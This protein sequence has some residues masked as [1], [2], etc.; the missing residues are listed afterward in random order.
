MTFE[1]ENHA[2][3][4]IEN[5]IVSLC[6]AALETHRARGSVREPDF[7]ERDKTHIRIR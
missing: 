2:V 4:K 7:A 1:N 3:F 6:E 5:M